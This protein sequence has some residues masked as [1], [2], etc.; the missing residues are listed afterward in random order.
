MRRFLRALD[1]H[2]FA[3]APLR[4][5][6]FFR[7]T[8]VAAQLLVFLP[9]LDNIR[10]LG[11][12][13]ERLW[14]P[15]PALKVL[16]WPFGWGARP[17]P[18]LLEGVLYLTVLAGILALIGLYTRPSL[19]AFAAGN[20]L[21]IAHGYSYG[22]YHHPDAAMVLALA[23]LSVSA[24]G[25]AWS[26][27]SLR[28]RIASAAY[29]MRFVPSGEAPPAS[30]EARWPLRLVQWLLVLVYLSAGMSK[31]AIGGWDWINGYTLAFYMAEDGL[32]WGLDLGLMLAGHPHLLSV[33]SVFALA[34]E[35]SFALAIVFPR[36]TWPYV[37]AGIGLHVGID[38]L[39]HARFF[40]YIVLYGAFIEPLR[41]GLPMRLRA[42]R[43][44]R[45]RWKVVYDGL[46][47]LCLRTM[48]I[49]DSLD[50]RKRLAFVDLEKE[51]PE[52]KRV[53]AGVTQDQA[54]H[55]MH[56]VAPDGKVYRGY[57]AFRALAALLPPM[58]PVLPLL[59]APTAASIGPRLYGLIAESRGKTVC[60]AE[61]CHI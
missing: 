7:I 6:A 43:P 48:V 56:V 20:A 16:L 41:G 10:R 22:E 37:L 58:W 17:D 40:Q 5:L 1:R 28:S 52:A 51:W 59:H 11:R 3:P 34:F 39:Q 44:A 14:Y 8:V 19:L 21:L 15:L 47:P 4:D 38:V 30:E 33:L 23:I 45:P 26:I 32:R 46:C 9:S 18:M 55:A 13:D 24:C 49:L 61:S 35:L 27:D 50:L 53:L 25:R 42:P 60:R 57:F 36:L 12:A 54:R 29:S 31:L 2:W